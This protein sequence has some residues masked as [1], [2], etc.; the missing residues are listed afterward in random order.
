MSDVS[1]I[2]ASVRGVDVASESPAGSPS[3]RAPSFLV[4]V[5]S[6][7]QIFQLE[8]VFSVNVMAGVSA[9]TGSKPSLTVASP[10]SGR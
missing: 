3:G 9:V 5:R 2:S 4:P 6:I 10:H 7:S 1:A 8:C